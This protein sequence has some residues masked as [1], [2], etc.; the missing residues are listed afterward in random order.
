M[1]SPT[2]PVPVHPIPNPVPVIAAAIIRTP[3]IRD[4]PIQTLNP[5]VR[6]LPVALAL[7][8]QTPPLRE[9][10][11]PVL[12]LVRVQLTLV[13]VLT[14]VPEVIPAHPILVRLIRVQPKIALVM[15]L[16]RKLL[17]SALLLIG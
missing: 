9:G 4:L 17:I 16:P 5:L 3:V 2:T 7:R 13:L 12:I 10:V 8:D 11:L 14:P 6:V 15:V 1:P